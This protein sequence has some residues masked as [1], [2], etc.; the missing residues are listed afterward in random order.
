MQSATQIFQVELRKEVFPH[1]FKWLTFSFVQAALPAEL[2]SDLLAYCAR[3]ERHEEK[4]C[5]FVQIDP[6]PLFKPRGLSSLWLQ[7]SHRIKKNYMGK[8]KVGP[9][10]VQCHNAD[11]RYA[12]GITI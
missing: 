9:G 12:I 5:S 7:A 4:S 3:T 6:Q 2:V 11:S 1:F 10:Y 8:A